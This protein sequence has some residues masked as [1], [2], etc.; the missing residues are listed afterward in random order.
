VIFRGSG[1]YSTD[2]RSESY[3]SGEKSES[4][5]ATAAAKADSKPGDATAGK[6][7]A[8]AKSDAPAKPDPPKA[9][10]PGAK[11]ESSSAGPSSNGRSEAG[12][13]KRSRGKE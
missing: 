6:T 12:S 1:F 11:S 9:P 4:G 3:K 5:A 13:R 8:T 7:D 10:A 2:Y